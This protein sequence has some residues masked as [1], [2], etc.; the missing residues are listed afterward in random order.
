MVLIL[1][2]MWIPVCICCWHWRTGTYLHALEPRLSPAQ[3]GRDRWGEQHK[4]PCPADSSPSFPNSLSLLFFF[5]FF[6]P[7]FP[8]HF[9]G[10]T[11]RLSL[12]HSPAFRRSRFAS[13][14]PH[15]C[16]FLTS[17]KVCCF[18]PS[19]V[20][21]SSLL[22]VLVWPSEQ[23]L[24]GQIHGSR[25]V[26]KQAEVLQSEELC[27]LFALPLLQPHYFVLLEIT[28]HSLLWL[29][30]CLSVSFLVFVSLFLRQRELWIFCRASTKRKYLCISKFFLSFQTKKK[31]GLELGGA[32]LPHVEACWTK[33]NVILLKGWHFEKSSP[34]VL[35]FNITWFYAICKF[36]F[37]FPFFLYNWTRVY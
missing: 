7:C 24:R 35:F 8:S 37:S 20:C 22:Y 3:P 10:R 29:S 30:V 6:S 25:R 17:A 33:T 27:F 2:Y 4:A 31:R 28:L 14:L 11:G 23:L 9:A 12:L 36:S 26:D 16:F 5:F 32:C 21:P 1:E 34:F 15:N 13:A 19:S 18:S